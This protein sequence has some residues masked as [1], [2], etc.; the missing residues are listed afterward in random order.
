MFRNIAQ[1]FG[2]I[3]QNVVNINDL[4]GLNLFLSYIPSPSGV[5]NKW[6]FGVNI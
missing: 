4:K 1:Y 6:Y 5:K 2:K 3:K